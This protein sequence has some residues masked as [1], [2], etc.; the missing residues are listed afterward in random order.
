MKKLRLNG[1]DIQVTGFEVL[2]ASA[3]RE[4]TVVGQALPTGLLCPT[5]NEDPTCRLGSCYSGSPCSYCP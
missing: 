2:P 1:D 5:N 4:G 3:P